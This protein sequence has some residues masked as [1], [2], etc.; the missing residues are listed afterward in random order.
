MPQVTY[1][2]PQQYAMPAQYVI[3]GGSAEIPQEAAPVQYVTYAAPPAE[4]VA[5]PGYSMGQS[6]TYLDYDNASFVV[7]DPVFAEPAVAAT[8]AAV[9]TTTKSLKKKSSKKKSKKSG[10]C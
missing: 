8:T 10:C 2:M 7:T 6:Y 4:A 1:A 5:A 9:T 3:Q